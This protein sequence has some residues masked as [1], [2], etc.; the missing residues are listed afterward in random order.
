MSG[1]CSAHQGHDP[2]CPMCNA[3]KVNELLAERAATKELIFGLPEEK[4]L[5]LRSLE[6]T[7]EKINKEL[8]V[9]GYFDERIRS[10]R[11]LRRLGC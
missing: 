10:F 2:N 8:E 1:A 4:L 9:F 5:E 6:T 11:L 7:L 3:V